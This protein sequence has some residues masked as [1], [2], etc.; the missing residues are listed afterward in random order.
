VHLEDLDGDGW[1][2]LFTCNG[3]VYPQADAEGTGTRYAQPP[4]LWRVRPERPVERVLPRR[5][6]SLLALARGTR[7]SAL[8][9]VDHD[10]APDLVL[11]AL[12]G[13]AALGMNRLAPEARRLV[14]ALE[15][16]PASP[17]PDGRRSTRD[18]LGAKA[19]LVPELP[20]GTPPEQEF[21]LLKEVAT[22]VG[23]QSSSSP[24]LHFGT[25]ALARYQALTVLW[26]SGRREELGAGAMGR[27]LFVREGQGIVRA[28]E[29]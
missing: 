6:D 28:E 19:I 15:G 10:G 5:R 23:Y 22:S 17:G 21:A 8:G 9:D 24:H 18:A 11:V 16:D 1:Q 27:R 26:P 20:P 7:G 29:L 12:D 13:P 2:E 3:H 14:L 4:T 25:G